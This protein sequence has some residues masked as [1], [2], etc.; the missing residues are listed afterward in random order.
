MTMEFSFNRQDFGFDEAEG[1]WEG[2]VIYSETADSFYPNPDVARLAAEDL[3]YSLK[4]MNFYLCA[5]HIPELQVED[6]EDRIPEGTPQSEL[7]KLQELLNV[8]N[9]A[10]TAIDCWGWS[11][12]KVKLKL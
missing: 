8:M 2:Q 12:T 3:G 6:F 11:P 4:D 9:S 10:L 1:E 7:D 5:V